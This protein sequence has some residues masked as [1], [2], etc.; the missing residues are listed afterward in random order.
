MKNLVRRLIGADRPKVIAVIG[1]TRDDVEAGLEHARTGSSGL[2][3]WAWCAADAEPVEGCER[4]FPKATAAGVRISLRAA[5][6]ALFIVAWTGKP[7]SSALKLLP[8]RV[9][10]FR[11]VICNEARGFSAAGP[12]SLARHAIWR[13]RNAAQ[14]G[15][16]RIID[17]SK[18]A[19]LWLHSVG[20]RAGERAVDVINWLH[21]LGYRTLDRTGS[22]TLAG[23][24]FLARYT[25]W[26]ALF[27]IQR[28]RGGSS[29][30][31]PIGQVTGGRF[32]EVRVS[33]RGWPRRRVDNAVRNRD[34]EFVVFR[35][36]GELANAEPLIDLARQT[37]AFAVATQCA[38]S[39]RVIAKHPFRRLQAGE[40]AQVFAPYSTLIVMRRDL[41]LQFGIPRAL[42]CGA[43]FMILFWKAAAAGLE[44]FVAGHEREITQEPA[45]ELEDA[46]FVTRLALTRALRRIGPAHARRLRGNLSWSA[47]ERRG[48]RGKT[49]VLVVSPY[50]PF[51]LSH[52]G[53]VRMYNLCGAM[54]GEIDF[55][56]ACFRE[57]DDTVR[58][59][60]L[61]EIF[62]EVYIVDADEK[63]PD[64]KVPAQVAEYRNSAMADLIRRLCG[65][66]RVDLVQ[67]E[68]TQMSEY[69]DCAG[70]VPVILVEHDVTFTLHRQI[71]ESMP[72]DARA[73]QQY[74]LWLAFE[75]EALQ[76]ANAVWTMSEGDREISAGSATEP[77]GERS[78][79]RI[80]P[81]F[82]QSPCL[83]SAARERNA[84][85]LARLPRCEA[86]GSRR[87]TP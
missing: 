79:C 18:G 23:L 50:L 11:F 49:R 6:P 63:N 47:T 30:E 10:P 41:L 15:G 62:R 85:G 54:A 81:A 60:A 42:T 39:K 53:A 38:W 87:T 37:N 35:R 77:G 59:P 80:F 24:A 72:E 64:P 82:A 27:A 31:I 1:I 29:A 56:L 3:V 68:Y 21:S 73:R 86:A 46:E 25:H 17:W 32:V 4:F 33:N 22:F 9:P 7:G 67:L 71:A 20:Y 84:G 5:W 69:R 14:S 83:R 70:A 45:M 2:P 51:P 75:R 55:V 66:H 36:Q 43:A 65:E 44:S 58:Y 12:V 16:R 26:I 13:M 52:G 40:A 74:E 34:A 28:L 78:V 48:F 57:V 76:R 61:H 8:F 19:G